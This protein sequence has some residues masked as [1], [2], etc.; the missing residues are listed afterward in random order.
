MKLKGKIYK[1]ADPFY[2]PNVWFYVVDY[3]TA[4]GKRDIESDSYD[5]GNVESQ[6]FAMTCV[7]EAFKRYARGEGE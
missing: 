4:M 6:E 1:D 3:T 7:Q 5:Y 2:E